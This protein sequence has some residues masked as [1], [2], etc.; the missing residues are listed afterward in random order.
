MFRGQLPRLYELRDLIDDPSS[1]DAYFQNFDK[2]IQDSTNARD[3]YDRWEKDLQSLDNGAWEFLK[4]EASPYLTHRDHGGRGWQ[5]L[6]DILNQAR[7]YNYFENIG[8]SKLRFIP[9]ARQDSTRTPDLEGDL[10]SGKIL[11][12]VKTI[13]ISQKE[14]RARKEFTVREIKTR[15]DDGFLGKLRSD[16]KEASDQLHAYDPTGEARHYA[17]I[18]LCFDD[19]L[20]EYKEEYFR[21]MDE[22]LS[23]CPTPRISL[24]FHNDHTPA[25]KAL[26]MSNATIVNA[27]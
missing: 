21:Q 25:H 11:C 4:N 16:I 15:L 3:I 8:A 23:S 2:H 7:A 12:E 27:D 14:A 20:G 6:F 18:N 19:F 26:A 13:N 24:I 1:P 5:Q 22:Y 17:Y 10:G 9:R